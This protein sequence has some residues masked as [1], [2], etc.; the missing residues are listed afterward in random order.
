MPQIFQND[1][2]HEGAAPR[3]ACVLWDMSKC[4]LLCVC[5]CEKLH[6]KRRQSQRQ[7]Q[8]WQSGLGVAETFA[9]LMQFP[10]ATRLLRDNSSGNGSANV[11]AAA[12]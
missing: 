8:C 10:E 11:K 3:L 5:V 1:A 9:Q 4:A 6:I 7:Q 2:R 12:R